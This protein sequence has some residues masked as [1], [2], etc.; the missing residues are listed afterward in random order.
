M[1]QT[2]AIFIDFNL[3]LK[4]SKILNKDIAQLNNKIDRVNRSISNKLKL[5]NFGKINQCL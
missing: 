2:G 5:M 3:C 1:H 4:I